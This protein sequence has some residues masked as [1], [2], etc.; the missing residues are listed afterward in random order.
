MSIRIEVQYASEDYQKL[1]KAN[2]FVCSMSRKDNRYDN[3]P[4]ESFWG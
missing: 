1:L 3:A 4:M 2:D